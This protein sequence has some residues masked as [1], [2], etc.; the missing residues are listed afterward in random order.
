MPIVNFAGDSGVA[1][2]WSA[3]FFFF[4]FGLHVSIVNWMTILV[5]SYF[6]ISAGSYL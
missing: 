4:F 5:H 6:K 3:F 1:I 2:P